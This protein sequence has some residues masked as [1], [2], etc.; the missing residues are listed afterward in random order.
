MWC[1]KHNIER[2][3]SIFLKQSFFD[4]LVKLRF[5]PGGPVAQYESVDKGILILVCRSLSAAEVELQRGY[6]EAT[7][8]TKSTR[9]LEDLLKEKN[10][11]TT[12]AQNYM[13]LKLNIGTFCALLWA[14]FRDQCDYY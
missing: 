7:K 12:P 9:R 6:E 1:R 8:L 11:T 5:N 10:K 4:D 3:K 2:D 14:L 13:E